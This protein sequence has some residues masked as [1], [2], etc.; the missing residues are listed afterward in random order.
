MSNRT[1]TLAEGVTL[2]LGDSRDVVPSIGDVSCV[3][4]SPPYGKQRDYGAKIADWQQLVSGSP[5]WRARQWGY[6]TTGET[7]AWCM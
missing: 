5:V 7:S 2:Y 3:V 4:T 1:E 6:A